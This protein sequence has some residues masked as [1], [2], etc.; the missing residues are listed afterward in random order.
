[1]GDVLAEFLRGVS[2]STSSISVT[3]RPDL[4]TRLQPV[5]AGGLRIIGLYILATDDS[6]RAMQLATRIPAA[7]RVGVI[8]ILRL[9]GE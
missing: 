7:R 9:L 4:A 2:S 8:E 1:M 5:P 6:E 3:T